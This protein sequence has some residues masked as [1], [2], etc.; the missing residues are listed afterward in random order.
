MV[1]F[2]FLFYLP[3]LAIQMLAT[4][5]VAALTSSVLFLILL[6]THPF[7]GHISI[8]PDAFQQAL[9]TFRLIDSGN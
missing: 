7:T 8:G 2:S 1:C 9:N 5:A 6:L 4:G 3:N